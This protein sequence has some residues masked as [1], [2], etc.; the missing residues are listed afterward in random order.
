[1]RG[2]CNHA[3]ARPES[4]RRGGLFTLTYWELFVVFVAPVHHANNSHD[5]PANAD[6]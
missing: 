5:T 1:M 4:C 6:T 2:Q 3:V